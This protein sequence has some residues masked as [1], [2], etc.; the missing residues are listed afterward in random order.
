MSEAIAE[1]LEDLSGTDAGSG[2]RAGSVGEEQALSA[3]I[4]ARVGK[5][6]RVRCS[7]T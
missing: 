3:S 6:R 7:S 4:D 5:H 2:E 1:G